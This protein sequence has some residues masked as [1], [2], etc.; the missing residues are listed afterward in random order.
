MSVFSDYARKYYELGYNVMPLIRKKAFV[1]NWSV[2]SKAHIPEELVEKWEN[3][4]RDSNDQAAGSGIGLIL[5]EAS[6][7]CA[8]D[9]DG[10]EPQFHQIVLDILGRNH[11]RKIGNRGF[12]LFFKYNSALAGFKESY[13]KDVKLEFLTDG[14]YTVL[15]PSFHEFDNVIFKWEGISLFDIKKSELNEITEEQLNACRKAVVN[16]YSTQKISQLTNTS[17]GRHNCITDYGFAIFKKC[18]SVDELSKRLLAYDQKNYP[19]NLYFSD[20][21]E[22]PHKTP[23]QA[24]LY[25]ARSIEKL[26]VSKGENYLQVNTLQ[27]S[28]VYDEYKN[29]FEN[30]PFTRQFKKDFLSREMKAKMQGQWIVLDNHLNKVKAD[31]FILGL[32][33]SMVEDFF[34]KWKFE[35]ELESLIDIPEWDKVSRIDSALSFVKVSGVNHEVF[36]SYFKQWC[37]NV[38]ARAYDCSFQN[39]CIILEGKQGV[40]KDTFIENMFGGFDCYFRNI[41]LTS[42]EKDNF[43]ATENLLIAN[44][45]EFDQ[46]AKLNPSTLKD[47]ISSSH[48]DYRGAYERKSMTKNFH[49]SYIATCNTADFLR[50][51]TGNRRFAPFLIEEIDWQYPKFDQAEKI[52][53]VAE[54]RHLFLS[55]FKYSDEDR[56]S[57]QLV[58][59]QKTPDDIIE[60]ALEVWD[61]RVSQLPPSSSKLKWS[62]LSDLSSEICKQHG[63]KIKN[64]QSALKRTGRQIRDKGSRYYVAKNQR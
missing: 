58:I 38:F 7:I 14:R 5:G 64:L 13:D 26:C 19:N 30:D 49:C 16:F 33:K 4:Y 6:D 27:N 21:K 54:M 39:F 63:I 52:Q 46:T 35:K 57:M 20:K 18:T 12:T 34:Y 3:Q 51:S 29:F 62:D 60:L 45:A 25:I 41:T 61:D 15:P 31:A 8:I 9:V 42:N 56:V 22:Y 17:N 24:A 32:K 28:S 59:E 44:V 2:W 37:A 47:L 10:T 48:K 36:V 53:V 1:H 50:D 23:E 40:G 55:E 43:S 11:P